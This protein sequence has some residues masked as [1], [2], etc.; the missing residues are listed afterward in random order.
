MTDF[1]AEG[2]IAL[3]LGSVLIWG[4][5]HFGGKV[6]S[7]IDD[8]KAFG[9]RIEAVVAKLEALDP[10]GFVAKVQ[11]DANTVATAAEA[12]LQP[13]IAALEPH[14]A[15]L[16]ALAGKIEALVTPPAPATAEPA[17]EDPR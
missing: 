17:A 11:A 7:V 8:F 5:L 10:T 14:V 1:I 3:F 16:E 15:S 13:I 6:M 2:L 4:A 12:E 9:A